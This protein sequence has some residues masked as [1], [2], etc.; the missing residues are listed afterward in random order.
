MTCAGSPNRPNPTRPDAEDQAAELS[1]AHGISEVPHDRGLSLV[2]RLEDCP[3]PDGYVI[4]EPYIV[5]AGRHPPDAGRR[6]R[7]CACRLGV[8]VPGPRCTST[9][10][11]TSWSSWPGGTAAGGSVPADPPRDHQERPQAGRRGRRR[12]AARDRGRGSGRPNGGWP[13]PRRPTTSAIARHP[14][15]RQLG[16]QADGKTFVTG[17][18]APWRVEPRYPTRPPHSPPTGPAAPWPP[19]RTPSRRPATTSSSRSARTR[20]WRPRCCTRSGSTRSPSTSPAGRP[21]ARPSRRWSR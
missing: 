13:P 2:T 21:A 8:A 5:A 18:D 17:Q 12:R 10:T 14:V 1:A 16:W 3:L 15:A 4:P 20:G 7:V 19:G 6:G 9:R 11:A